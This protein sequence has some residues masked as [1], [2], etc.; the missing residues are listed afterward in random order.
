MFWFS[1]SLKSLF[2]SFD[3][4]IVENLLGVP[5]VDVKA[6]NVIRN[7]YLFKEKSKRLRYTGLT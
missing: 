7:L 4:E 5:E 2:S 6:F 1:Q 3:A